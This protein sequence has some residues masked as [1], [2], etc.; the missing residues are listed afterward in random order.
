MPFSQRRRRRGAISSSRARCASVSGRLSAESSGGSAHATDCP[1]PTP[2]LLH[3]N[4][5]IS[6]AMA[7]SDSERELGDERRPARA[8]R[9]DPDPA[10]HPV[11]ELTADV[12]AEARAADTAREVGVEA[13]ELLEDPHVLGGRDAETLVPD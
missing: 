2:A 6:R 7:W 11:E 13:I 10:A 8:A 5:F 4:A 12:E 3:P 1:P 9:L